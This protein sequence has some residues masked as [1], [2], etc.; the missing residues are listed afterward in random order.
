[1][2]ATILRERRLCNY[3]GNCHPEAYDDS[4]MTVPRPNVA[5]GGIVVRRKG[6]SRN[7]SEGILKFAK[8]YL[9]P[10]IENRSD[11]LVR[12]KGGIAGSLLTT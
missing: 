10:A 12:W 1:M 7:E 8:V 9:Q 3:R 6:A 4:I 5:N 2:Q 11:K